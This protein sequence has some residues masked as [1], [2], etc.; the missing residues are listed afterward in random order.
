MH[1]EM[2]SL[3]DA[4]TTYE[5]KDY[6]KILPKLN[7]WHKDKNRIKDGKQVNKGFS[8]S[9]DKNKSWINSEDLKKWLTEN[10]DKIIED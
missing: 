3:Q 6:Y 7:G 10:S 8:Y 1:E 4:E 9:S 2:I 5:Y